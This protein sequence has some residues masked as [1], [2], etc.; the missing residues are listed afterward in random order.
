MQAERT[1]NHI[2][3]CRWATRQYLLPQGDG[4]VGVSGS[5]PDV[6]GCTDRPNIVLTVVN[7]RSIV[8]GIIEPAGGGSA[9]DRLAKQ[10]NL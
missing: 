1:K 2:S 3:Q 9:V 5:P 4:I 10:D 6:F 7:S 8:V